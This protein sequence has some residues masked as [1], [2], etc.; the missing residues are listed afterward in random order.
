MREHATTERL[1]AILLRSADAHTHQ[2]VG[3][4]NPAE[5][6]STR[7]ARRI[8]SPKSSSLCQ[9]VIHR[10]V[11][12]TDT[13]L[14]RAA[15]RMLGSH[16]AASDAVQETWLT[17]FTKPPRTDKNVRGWLV[18]VLRNHI[19]QDLRRGREVRREVSFVNM[20]DRLYSDTR[21]ATTG[22]LRRAID[23]L[24]EPERGIIRRHFLEGVTFTAIAR[25]YKLSA[26][27]VRKR[28]RAGIELLRRLLPSESQHPPV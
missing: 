14:Q 18:A 20:D 11:K 15:L 1:S 26:P 4:Q 8:H 24:D 27:T 25:H 22:E 13:Y 2:R 21:Y 19:R 28:C 23:Q 17:F 7:S 10:D 9:A 6:L 16:E 3:A 12:A 5:R